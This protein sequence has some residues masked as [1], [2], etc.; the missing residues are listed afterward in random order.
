M[1]E[2]AVTTQTLKRAAWVLVILALV[3]LV[4]L[5]GR[6]LF[7]WTVSRFQPATPTPTPDPAVMAAVQGAEAF[8]TINADEGA[9]G[10]AD[11][12]CRVVDDP[13]TCQ[14]YRQLFMPLLIRP[15]LN[16]HPDLK[17]TARVGEAVLVAEESGG[18]D[19]IY[20]LQV[21]VQGLP[22][23]D[24]APLLVQVHLGDDGVWRFVRPLF[25]EEAGRYLQATPTP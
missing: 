23:N 10:W 21:T 20:R 6:P 25:E 14:V 19:R 16:E 5:F 2:I 17:V 4:A 1:R 11:R 15:L 3:A 24:D 22:Q 18:H 12:L 13:D 9:E 7:S 8:Y